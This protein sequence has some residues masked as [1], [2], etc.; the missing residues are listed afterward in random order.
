M[1]RVVRGRHVRAARAVEHG[2]D[3]EA[4]AE[5][6]VR[7]RRPFVQVAHEIVHTLGRHAAGAMSSIRSRP[8]RSTREVTYPRAVIDVLYFADK[9]V[10]QKLF[11]RVKAAKKLTLVTV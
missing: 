2:V 8:R 3:V 4:A 9:Q 5:G 7:I 11:D 10:K 6:A 1:R